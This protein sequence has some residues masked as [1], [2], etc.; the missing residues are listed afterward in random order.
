MGRGRDCRTVPPVSLR[1]EGRA[2]PARPLRSRS[3]RG[4]GVGAS[5][6]RAARPSEQ[7]GLTPA[8]P[9]APSR[10]LGVRPHGRKHQSCGGCSPRGWALGTACAIGSGP[11]W[12]CIS[13]SRRR[14][15]FLPGPQ[16]APRVPPPGQRRR[17]RAVCQGPSQHPGHP[18]QR[19]RHR[20]GTQQLRGLNRRRCFPR[21]EDRSSYRQEGLASSIRNPPQHDLL[22][23]VDISA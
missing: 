21:A 23:S 14:G 2:P 4:A 16:P 7:S 8:L 3:R 12:V 15:C 22:R 17:R 5:C 10:G 13:G 18:G 20:A 9:S 6:P 19:R 1:G 11:S